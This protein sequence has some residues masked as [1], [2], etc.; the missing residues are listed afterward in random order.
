MTDP[1]VHDGDWIPSHGHEEPFPDDFAKGFKAGMA[2]ALSLFEKDR[3]LRLVFG[4]AH[5]VD[6]CWTVCRYVTLGHGDGIET[7]GRG[8]TPGEAV[9]DA[10][11]ALTRVPRD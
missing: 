8:E 4:G 7:V 11:A 6:P 3:D 10:S 9:R 1:R 2:A 5:G